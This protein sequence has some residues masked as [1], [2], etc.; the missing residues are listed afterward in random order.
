M[1]R[2]LCWVVSATPH[3]ACEEGV[4]GP[5]L[6][7]SV[8]KLAQRGQWSCLRARGKKPMCVHRCSALGTSLSSSSLGGY[9][10]PQLTEEETAPERWHD[11]PKATQ[12]GAARSRTGLSPFPGAPSS[13]PGELPS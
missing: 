12:P 8:E 2:A 4:V 11:S 10:S 7:T 3:S 5:P 1:G 6:P 9:H 13:L